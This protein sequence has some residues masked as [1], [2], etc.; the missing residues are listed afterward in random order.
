MAIIYIELH[1]D[2]FYPHTLTWLSLLLTIVLLSH[3]NMVKLV[4]DHI[5]FQEYMLF[6]FVCFLY[7]GGQSIFT[8]L[9]KIGKKQNKLKT[10]YPKNHENFKNSKPRI[11]F[12]W[13]EDSQVSLSSIKIGKKQNKSK[14]IYPKNHGNFKNNKLRVQFY[15]YL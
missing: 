12:Y 7:I 8:F 9:H 6:K 10:I 4:I 1:V 14:T 3:F 2:Q 11:Q 15:W 13:F 5:L